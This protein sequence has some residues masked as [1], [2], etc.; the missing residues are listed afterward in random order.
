MPERVQ[1]I[2]DLAELL[3]AEKFR[4]WLEH[5]RWYASKSRRVTGISIAESVTLCEQ[6][7]LLLALLETGFATGN[8]EL[9][10]VPVCLRPAH[11]RAGAGI[12][13]VAKIGSWCV[14]DALAEADQAGRL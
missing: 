13:P 8:H 4:E 9:Y 3:D 2:P 10:Q 14:Y 12:S 1:T 6:P 7:Q 11:E 5:Q